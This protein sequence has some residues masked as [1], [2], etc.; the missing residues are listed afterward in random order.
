MLS[1]PTK[2]RAVVVGSVVTARRAATVVVD[3]GGDFS[4]T[5]SGAA[6]FGA[7]T[8]GI[9][10]AAIAIVTGLWAVAITYFTGADDIVSTAGGAIIIGFSGA[11]RGTAS[12]PM[13]AADNI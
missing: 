9:D 4:A 2:G 5:T 11:T 8:E 3:A 12:V 7:S 6:H 1:I 13:G 10:G